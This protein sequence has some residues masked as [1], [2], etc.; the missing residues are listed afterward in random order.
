MMDAKGGKSDTRSMDCADFQQRLPELFESGEDLKNDLHLAGCE[1]C[2]ALVED[3]QY[4][5]QQAKLLLPI[6]DPS[7][8]VWDNIQSALKRETS[9]AK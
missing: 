8:E 5:A 1:N 6:H 2:A 7:P 4:I 9:G 3:L